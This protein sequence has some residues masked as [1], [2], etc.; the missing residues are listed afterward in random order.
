MTFI[1][2]RYH[3]V[4]CLIGFSYSESFHW[5]I[6][7]FEL[8]N[9]I[10]GAQQEACQRSLRWKSAVAVGQGWNVTDQLSKYHSI[11]NTST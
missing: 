6:I 5:L 8:N 3:N 4:A 9:S 11:M 10:L 1:E 2:S 7:N